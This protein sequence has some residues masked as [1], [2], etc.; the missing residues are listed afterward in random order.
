M[1]NS[2]DLQTQSARNYLKNNPTWHLEDS[3]WKAKQIFKMITQNTLSP[4]NIVEV[5]CGVG[6]IL[7]QLYQLLPPHVNFEG[8]DISP[9]AIKLSKKREKKRLTFY[10]KEY[11]NEKKGCDLLLL[12][13]VFEHVEN[14]FPFLRLLREKSKYSIFHIP[15]ELHAQGILRNVPIAARRKVG[16]L[17]HFSKDTAIATLMDCGYEIVDFFY[18]NES[19]DL[20]KT[21]KSKVMNVPRRILFS[22]N[23]DFTVRLLGG[24]SLLVL[25]HNMKI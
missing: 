5:G 16:H 8:Y 25:T 10:L 14:Y 12:I 24:F 20:K 4:K 6:E 19:F 7:N 21:F 9:Y 18:T 2:T 1:N 13:D 17:H 11:L 15:L 22:I 23:K 3:F